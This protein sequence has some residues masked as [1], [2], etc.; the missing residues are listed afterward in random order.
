MS[1]CFARSNTTTAF[2]SFNCFETNWDAV[3]VRGMGVQCL[4]PGLGDIVR[5]DRRDFTGSHS[6]PEIR[7][8][9]V[10]KVVVPSR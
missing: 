10:G 1:L 4:C 5:K 6:R 9:E 8:S 7:T 3:D 2:W